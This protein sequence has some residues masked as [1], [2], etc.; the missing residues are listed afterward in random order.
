MAALPTRLRTVSLHLLGWVAVLVVTDVLSFQPALR[1]RNLGNNPYELRVL[2]TWCLLIGFFYLNH[3]LLI[4]RYYLAG[5][6]VVYGLLALLSLGA[7]LLVPQLLVTALVGSSSGLPEV[8]GRPPRMGMGRTSDG[9]P[10]RGRT[11]EFGTYVLVYIISLLG[12][13]NYL[14]QQ[15]LREAEALGMQRHLSQLKAQIQPHFLFNT[16]N[17]I[18][19]LAVRRDDRTADTI[20]QLSEFL[21]YV[22]TQQ[23]SNE[24]VELRRELEYIEN[25][26]AL[27]QARLRDSVKVDYQVRGDPAGMTIAPLLLITY[28]EN[29]FKHGVSP[30]EPCEISIG[31]DTGA[32]RVTLCV[33]NTI[34][35]IRFRESDSGIGLE[36]TRQRL[37]LLYPGRH[38]LTIH[39]AQDRYGV[40][41][42][43]TEPVG[44]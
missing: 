27:Q 28:I 23:G 21:R 36:N 42:T 8:H 33:V 10:P 34:V 5:R 29:A 30:E 16:L 35:A 26:L 37:E 2:A 25:Y 4:P 40:T 24:P 17:S 22:V 7:I 20:V 19:A 13:V 39:K 12:S 44:C 3:Y 32:A 41:L 38:E 11:E 9:G 1:L 14:I 43:I 6:R 31:V 15:R 18:Y